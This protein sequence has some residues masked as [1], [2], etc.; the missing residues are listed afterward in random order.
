MVDPNSHPV[1]LE[2][3]PAS[4]DL[5]YANFDGGQIR[6]IQYLAV[7]HPP[8]AVA[9]GNPTSGPAPLTVQFN[10]SGSWDQRDPHGD[11]PA[12]EIA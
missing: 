12:N 8:T 5:F 4:G 1:D 6:R 11:L 9:T 3:D 10:G 7:N 2:A